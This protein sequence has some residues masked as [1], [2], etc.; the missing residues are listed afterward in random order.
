MKESQREISKFFFSKENL[1]EPI[2][3]GE[4][5]NHIYYIKKQSKTGFIFLP[6]NRILFY[7]DSFELTISMN[8]HKDLHE[9]SLSNNY[10]YHYHPLVSQNV[11]MCSICKIHRITNRRCGYTTCI[12]QS[13]LK[14]NSWVQEFFHAEVTKNWF[15]VLA[16]SHEGIIFLFKR[17]LLHFL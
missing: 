7:K 1:K 3:K 14:P 2:L 13:F 11:A 4:K 17:L 5:I 12:C 8:K 6:Q 10:Y 9:E 16:N 15:K